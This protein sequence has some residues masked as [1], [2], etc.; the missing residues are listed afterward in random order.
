MRYEI[1]ADALREISAA[2]DWHDSESIGLGVDLTQAYRV[3]LDQALRDPLA[4]PLAMRLPDGAE[5][6]RY[7]LDRF[8]RYS[9]LML[10]RNGDKPVVI[11]FEHSSRR[12]GYWHNRL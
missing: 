5:V 7:R 8:Y 4:A 6:R 12:P 2:A 11:A 3:S 1:R 9:I 10:L